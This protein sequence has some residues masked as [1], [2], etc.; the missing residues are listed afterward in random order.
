M[1]T[2][3]VPETNAARN[4]MSSDVTTASVSATALCVTEEWSAQMVV[5][6]STVQVSCLFVLSLS[7]LPICTVT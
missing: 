1:V 2:S 5:M 6:S 3:T 4:A 7:E